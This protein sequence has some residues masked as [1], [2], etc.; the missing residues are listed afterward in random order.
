M[1][2]NDY[3]CY[4]LESD[5]VLNEKRVPYIGWFWR[6]TWF[7]TKHISIGKITSDQSVA[8]KE[9]NHQNTSEIEELTNKNK[10]YNI[11]NDLKNWKNDGLNTLKYKLLDEM[12][13]GYK[14][15][16]K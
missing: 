1:Y 7:S 4:L 12:E 14:N 3:V 2:I 13:L 11:L 9:M 8:I 15:V 6:T 5:K 10:K 16:K